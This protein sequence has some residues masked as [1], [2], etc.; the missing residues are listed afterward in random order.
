MTR[1]VYAIDANK[2]AKHLGI[3]RNTLLKLLRDA[4]YTHAHTPRKNLPKTQFRKAGLFASSLTEF[5]AGP[6]KR[7]HEKLT[8][9]PAGLDVCRELMEQNEKRESNG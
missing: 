7:L 9:S 6:V 8:I 2:A 3:G 5:Y 4:G 1:T